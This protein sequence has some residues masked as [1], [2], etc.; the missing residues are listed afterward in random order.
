[1]TRKSFLSKLIGVPAAFTSV[2]IS[3][4]LKKDNLESLISKQLMDIKPIVPEGAHITFFILR[5]GFKEWSNVKSIAK[6]KEGA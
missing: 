4:K 2:A 1:M 5:P 6:A 3:P